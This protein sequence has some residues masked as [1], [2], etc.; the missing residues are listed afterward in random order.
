MTRVPA[1]APYGPEDLPLGAA[2]AQATAAERGATECPH[3]RCGEH[4]AAHVRVFYVR[5][6]RVTL[7]A[8]RNERA[9][10]RSLASMKSSARRGFMRAGDA[11]PSPIPDRR[12]R[13]S[14][15]PARRR[16]RPKKKNVGFGQNSGARAAFAIGGDREVRR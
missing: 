6:G 16:L 12:S 3:A 2:L 15:N 5:G 4:P 13:V 7:R 1:V 11:S 8:R 14:R 10:A 9:S